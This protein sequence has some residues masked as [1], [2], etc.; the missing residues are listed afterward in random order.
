MKKSLCAVIIVVCVVMLVIPGCKRS[1][2]EMG[3]PIVFNGYPMDA[4][5]WTINWFAAEGYIPNAVYASAEQS[6]F[7]QWLQEML[8]VKI[9]WQF[10]IR[11]TPSAQA[12]NLVL[13][14]FE[15]PDIIYGNIMSGAESYIL[16]GVFRDLTPYM[17]KWS[18]AYWKLL[19][20][21]P[22]YDRAMKTDSGK[23]Y[24]YGFFRE[25]GGWND[26]F[27]G[28]VVN[29]TWLDECGLPL[30]VTISDWDKTIRTFKE[31]Y[32]ATL[33]F[34]WSRVSGGSPFIAGA[35]GA[36]AFA[37]YKLYIDEN[38]K[39]QLANIQSE[40][41]TQL[42]QF[43]LWWKDGLI[44]QNFLSV[45]DTIA[46]SNAMNKRMGISFT[47][48]GQLSNWVQDARGQN[49]GAQWV[50]LAY[51]TGD[52]GTLVTVPGGLGIGHNA[53]VITTAVPD[54]MLELVMRALDYAYTEEGNLFWNYGKRG[55][56]WDFDAD[57]KPAYL[58]LVTEDPNGL[59][60]AIDKYG[61]STWSGN[62]IQATALLHMKNTPQAIEANN[63]WFYPNEAITWSNK[64]PP[65]LTLTVKET[66]RV[67]EL[68][69]SISTYVDEMSIR[70][71][72]GRTNFNEWDSYVSRV[73]SMG[74][75][76]L[77]RIYQAAYDRYLA[78]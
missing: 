45:N 38:H 15:F 60:D 13:A 53:A 37:D 70:F 67:G 50:G 31:R 1:K 48:M 71:I 58:P 69:G 3:E 78:R 40:Y 26:T 20:S 75:S 59:N 34:A 22:A 73:N 46:R 30:P 44:D 57:G 17:E 66:T 4:P 49:N 74:V 63:L 2:R 33:S 72:T 29:K 10:S 23:Y 21:N 19:Q 18:P 6:P 7:H 62:C 43:A 56:S 36:H 64:L 76:E 16:E 55:V 35:F 5:G 14:S 41:R 65:G 61:G 39:V 42:E 27:L 32:G 47:S 25:D 28:P 51:P 52:D 9:A 77:I 12:I 11:G 54:E 68:Q 24:G 8:G